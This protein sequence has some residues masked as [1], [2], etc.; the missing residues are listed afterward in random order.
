MYSILIAKNCFANLLIRTRSFIRRAVSQKGDTLSKYV[1]KQ[2]SGGAIIYYFGNTL[3]FF[4]FMGCS[5][6][7]T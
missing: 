1:D 7:L 3:N 4:R 6:Y 2:K 5:I